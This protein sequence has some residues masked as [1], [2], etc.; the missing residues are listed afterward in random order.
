MWAQKTGRD[1]E[2]I[3]V[4]KMLIY[5]DTDSIDAKYRQG[6]TVAYMKI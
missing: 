3:P 6:I 1:L 5:S 4:I 2:S